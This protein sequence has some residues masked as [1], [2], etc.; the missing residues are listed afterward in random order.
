M[1]IVS[2]PEKELKTI[3]MALI[4]RPQISD[5]VEIK[6]EDITNLAGSMSEVGLLQPPILRTTETRFEIVAG[7]RRILAARSLGWTRI[8]C[9]VCQLDDKQTA[10]IRA[11]EN[12][13]RADL[14]VIE[15]ARI[16][17]NLHETHGMR[18]DQIAKRMRRSSGIVKRRLDLLKMPDCLITATHKKL[19]SYGVAESLWT[20]TDP[21]ALDYYLSF[22][23]DHGVTVPIARQWANDWKAS[24]RRIEH[25][26]MDPMEQ[27]TSPIMRPTYIAC[28]LCQSPALV[29]DLA[30]IRICRE[31]AKKIT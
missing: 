30:V 15:E 11:I 1:T 18:I 10:E 29:Q 24:Q 26:N 25:E 12:L 21:D 22:A 13:E 6:E 23:I 17:K 7:D 19:I 28:D 27:L 9:F 4:D 14:S 31:C 5:R 20:I 3:S 8:E 16:Y 2:V